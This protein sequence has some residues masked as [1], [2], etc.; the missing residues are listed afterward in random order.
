MGIPSWL[1]TDYPLPTK[2]KDFT[3]V[4]RVLHWL[5]EAPSHHC[6]SQDSHCRVVWNQRSRQQPGSQPSHRYTRYSCL[7]THTRDRYQYWDYLSH[8]IQLDTGN[9]LFLLCFQYRDT[10]L[11]WHHTHWKSCG[12]RQW[13]SCRESS[14]WEIC[15][16]SQVGSG[17]RWTHLLQGDRDTGPCQSTGRRLRTGSSCSQSSQ[18]RSDCSGLE[19]NCHS[20]DRVRWAGSHT[21]PFVCHI[22]NWW[23]LQHH[24]HTLQWNKMVEC[25]KKVSLSVN[26]FLSTNIFLKWILAG[27]VQ[28]THHYYQALTPVCE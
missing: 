6:S 21:A 4:Q 27:L 18:S 17:H 20:E 24:S 9:S 2:A 22:L 10:G 5:W 8:R 19:Y 3:L 25:L 14:Q 26:T 1:S 23:I 11:W 15:H 28:L 7:N 16:S 12:L 13:S